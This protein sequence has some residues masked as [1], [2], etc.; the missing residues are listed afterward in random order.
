MKRIEFENPEEHISSSDNRI[1]DWLSENHGKWISGGGG[2]FS[3]TKDICNEVMKIMKENDTDTIWGSDLTFNF[4]NKKKVRLL[5]LVTNK[6]IIG[7]IVD[8][9]K[10][11][12]E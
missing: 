2:G 3:I 8:V 11:V 1:E 5:K 12:G 10:G 4:D 7:L 6:K 9:K